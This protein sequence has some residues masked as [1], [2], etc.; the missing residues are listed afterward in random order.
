MHTTKGPEKSCSK[1]PAQLSVT[2]A[3]GLAEL[4]IPKAQSGECRCH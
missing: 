2:S 4:L 1:D 3:A